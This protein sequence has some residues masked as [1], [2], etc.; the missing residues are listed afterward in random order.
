[1]N[2][3]CAV[4]VATLVGA[5]WLFLLTDVAALYSA[6]PQL[7]PSAVPIRE[8]HDIMQLQVGLPSWHHASARLPCAAS[9]TGTA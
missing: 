2:W 1:M 6:N 4:Q 7:D 5:S 3:T 9:H 8:V